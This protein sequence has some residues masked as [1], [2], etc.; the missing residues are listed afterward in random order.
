MNPF[1]IL[2]VCKIKTKEGVKFR[3]DMTYLEML[4]NVIDI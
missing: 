2:K 1:S 3:E 4:K